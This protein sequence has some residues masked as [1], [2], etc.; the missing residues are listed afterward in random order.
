MSEVRGILSGLGMKF[1]RIFNTFKL[2]TKHQLSLVW[3]YDADIYGVI[4]NIFTSLYALW[5]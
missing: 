3:I 5:S 4:R 1:F 2:K